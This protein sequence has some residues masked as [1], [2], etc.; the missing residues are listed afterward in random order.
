MYTV[1]DGMG[2]VNSCLLLCDG[3]YPSLDGVK[4]IQDKYCQC[5]IAF[6]LEALKTQKG[7]DCFLIAIDD[8]EKTMV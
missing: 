1:S 5:I 3:Y 7:L 6:S 2:V 4:E 8:S